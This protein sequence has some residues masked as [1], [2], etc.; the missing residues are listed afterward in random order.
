MTEVTVETLR[1][2]I[3]RLLE[4]VAE[5]KRECKACGATIYF[6]VHKSGKRAPYTGDALNHFIDCPRA[7]EFRKK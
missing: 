6:V 3:H 7:R 5:E 4:L 1:E 2:N